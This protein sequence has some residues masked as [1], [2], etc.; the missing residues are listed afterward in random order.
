MHDIE[1]KRRRI[2]ALKRQI[3]SSLNRE[4]PLNPVM[5]NS[6]RLNGTWNPTGF[7]RDS[8]YVNSINRK[9]NRRDWS[10]VQ[11]REGR[12]KNSKYTTCTYIHYMCA[13]AHKIEIETEEKEEESKKFMNSGKKKEKK[14]QREKRGA[15]WGDTRKKWHCRKIQT[16]EIQVFIYRDTIKAKLM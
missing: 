13:C 11:L 5:R 16:I 6:T 15:R 9:T 7:I 12:K 8:S 3:D 4:R 10:N 14:K 2:K 1:K